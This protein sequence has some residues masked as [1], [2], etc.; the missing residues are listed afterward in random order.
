MRNVMKWSIVLLIALLSVSHAVMADPRE[1]IKKGGEHAGEAKQFFGKELQACEKNKPLNAELLQAWDK[2]GT[3]TNH[4][5]E[6]TEHAR[7]CEYARKKV[8]HLENILRIL[9]S[10]ENGCGGSNMKM[11]TSLVQDQLEKAHAQI[12]D[13]C[14][15]APRGGSQMS[16]D[17]AKRHKDMIAALRRSLETAKNYA[18]QDSTSG[19]WGSVQSLYL[20]LADEYKRV[21]DNVNANAMRNYADIAGDFAKNAEAKRSGSRSSGGSTPSKGVKGKTETPGNKSS[22]YR[23]MSKQQCDQLYQSRQAAEKY[24]A[25]E[26]AKFQLDNAYREGNCTR[27]YPAP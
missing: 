3:V 16:N 4:E 21:G 12:N 7:Y 2:F 8:P 22:V 23:E 19:N 14:A 25:D 15:Q 26:T 5:P 9:N 1:G 18:T 13:T 17:E 24:G 27:Y 10:M 11:Q 20:H 6:K